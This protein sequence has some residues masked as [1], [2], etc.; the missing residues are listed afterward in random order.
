LSL[1]MSAVLLPGYH[2]VMVTVANDLGNVSAV[3]NVSVL[4]PVNV[5]HVTAR[6]V[7]LARPFVLETLI[8]GDLDFAV[9]VDFGDGSY[10]NCSTPMLH[11][12]IIITPLT[13]ASCNRSAP[14]Y[15]L[16]LRHLYVTPG[17]YLV[18]LSVANRVSHVTNLLTA[19]VA[20]DDFNVMLTAD[21]QSPISSDSVIT[22]RAA[23]MTDGDVSFNWTCGQCASKPLIH[24]SVLHFAICCSTTSFLLKWKKVT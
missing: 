21:R 7:T 6:P 5:F 4:Y 11:P 16:K 13:D 3:L 2:V 20:D 23:A 1:Q 24:G 22:L 17:D 9:S 19:N 8:S 15:L 14:V 10:V 12:D 18:S